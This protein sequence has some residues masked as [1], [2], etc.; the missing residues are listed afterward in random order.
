MS[1]W[2][3]CRLFDLARFESL[4]EDF[5]ALIRGEVRPSVRAAALEGLARLEHSDAFGGDRA[6][7]EQYF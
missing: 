3:E 7:P 6:R 1:V 4:K 5:E 2:F